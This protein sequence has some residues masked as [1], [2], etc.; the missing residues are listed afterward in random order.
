MARFNKESSSMGINTLTTQL[1]KWD[2]VHKKQSVVII[3]FHLSFKY[4]G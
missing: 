1:L 2:W 3:F 4:N